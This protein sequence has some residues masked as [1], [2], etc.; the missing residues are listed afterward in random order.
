[1]R[2]PPCSWKTFGSFF[3]AGGCGW[4]YAVTQIKMKRKNKKVLDD[5]KDV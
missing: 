4:V 1:V 2:S 5:I 3:V